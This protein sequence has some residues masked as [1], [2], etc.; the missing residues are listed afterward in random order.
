LAI[1]RQDTPG[2]K[3]LVLYL[4]FEPSATVPS[5][6]E[7]R[8]LLKQRVPDYMIPRTFVVL[9]EFPLTSNGKI[10]RKALPA[11]D[12]ARPDLHHEF[13]PP[14]SVVEKQL[15]GIWEQ[16]LGLDKVGIH[17][18]FF[19][20]GGDSILMIQI[21]S[22]A[23]QAGLTL[24]LRQIFQHQ[25]IAELAQLPA[26]AQTIEAEQELVTGPVPLTPAQHWFIDQRMVEP[27]HYN[28]AVLLELRQPMSLALLKRVVGQLL[29]HHDGFRSRLIEDETGW[30]QFVSA[31]PEPRSF[32]AID[33]SALPASYHRSA[34]Q[35]ASAQLQATLNLPD[36]PIIRFA[37]F[38]R[39][40][41][42]SAR[43]LIVAH[44]L[45]IDGVSWRVLLEDLQGVYDQ[46]ARKQEIALPPKT[47]SF[48]SWAERLAGHAQ[49]E[50]VTRE[51]HYWITAARRRSYPIPVDYPSTSNTVGSAKSFSVVLNTQDTQALL[52]TV[53]AAYNTRIDEVLLTALGLTF[54][55]WTGR[56]RLL[57]DLES[58]GREEIFPDVD[59][60]RSIGWFTSIYPVLL[61]LGGA[62]E[63]RAALK[64]TKTQLREIPN[65]GLGYG[66]L[67]YLRSDDQ[68]R[69]LAQAEVIFNYLGQFDQSFTESSYFR[70]ASESHGSSR[71]LKQTRRHLL[72]VN[73]SVVGKELH[74]SWTYS[75]QL[76]RE[77]TIRHLAHGY[78]DALQTLIASASET[79][80]FR[81]PGIPD[82]DLSRAKVEQILAELDVS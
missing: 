46:L 9:D 31:D 5:T 33:L 77:S 10:D 58:H 64:A 62:T 39:G 55:R 4:T 11:P 19:E 14:A 36:G 30:R 24:A 2:D 68:L 69:E 61:D 50:E 18:N 40:E 79:E 41:D 49:S 78:L 1:A 73:C 27:H 52:Q 23:R 65:R 25:T 66:L 80:V 21:I 26:M 15:A 8:N 45:T 3:Y 56:Q 82:L 57:V 60:S 70:L 16:V 71:S 48:K 17:D 72:E 6:S 7:L 54:A 63:P 76:H 67:R 81:L 12:G 43:L 20:L 42:S 35:K 13:A 22:R 32:C 44:H 53:P 74:V 59:L 75:E 34:I 29:L 28:Q 38:H 37:F 47:T 51:L